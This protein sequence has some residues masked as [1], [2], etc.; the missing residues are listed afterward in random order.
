MWLL[1]YLTDKILKHLPL[2]YTSVCLFFGFH[3]THLLT[4]PRGNTV[5]TDCKG[6]GFVPS[7]ICPLPSWMF[8]RWSLGLSEP[9]DGKA[10]ILEGK[11]KGS[12]AEEWLV[13]EQLVGRFC[14]GCKW[15]FLKPGPPLSY[16]AEAGSG[17]GKGSLSC[18]CP[19]LLSFLRRE[20]LSRTGSCSQTLLYPL[21]CVWHAQGFC[22]SVACSHGKFIHIDKNFTLGR[23]GTQNVNGLIPLLQKVLYRWR[24]TSDLH[25]E[26]SEVGSGH[27][28]LG[29]PFPL[30][31]TWLNQRW[32][33]LGTPAMTRCGLS[34]VHL[35]DRP[36]S[37]EKRTFV[38]FFLPRTLLSP[39]QR[40][41]KYLMF[42]WMRK[43]I[44]P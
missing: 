3:E 18:S 15:G 33:R 11:E 42:W 37:Q 9:R 8:Y 41:N 5:C 17:S 26:D 4:R 10:A 36:L 35:T 7:K 1:Q 27:R 14:M 20:T 44:K 39:P 29:S 32:V 25:S 6:D 31:E 28:C 43:W 23:L 30:V 19:A 13:A 2:F 16:G 40:L 22:V 12:V 21:V 34:T 38:S 24:K